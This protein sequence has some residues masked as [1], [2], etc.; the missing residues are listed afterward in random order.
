MSENWNKKHLHNRLDSIFD[1][2]DDPTHLPGMSIFNQHTGWIWEIDDQGRFTNCSPDVE[3]LLGYE[4]RNLIGQALSGISN[5]DLE[6]AELPTDP[7][8]PNPKVVRVTFFHVDGSQLETVCHFLPLHQAGTL[9]GWRG[10]TIVETEEPSAA[11]PTS[12]DVQLYSEEILLPLPDL[13]SPEQQTSPPAP[14]PSSNG[15]SRLRASARWAR[16]RS[17]SARMPIPARLSRRARLQNSAKC[18]T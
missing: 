12:S 17:R 9:L 13:I 14:I 15:I 3:A 16:R 4:A 5:F 18:A 7:A 10:M 2:L 8:T 11:A 6:T 1:D